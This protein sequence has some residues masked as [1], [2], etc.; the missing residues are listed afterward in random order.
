MHASVE[1]F[2]PLYIASLPTPWTHKHA[3]LYAHPVSSRNQIPRSLMTF[4]LRTQQPPPWPQLPL[5]HYRRPPVHLGS[6]APS[7]RD[8]SDATRLPQPLPRRSSTPPPRTRTTT[9]NLL[10][11]SVLSADLFSSKT[12]AT[13]PPSPRPPRGSSS[14]GRMPPGTATPHTTPR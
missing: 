9:F 3:L 12:M 11:S 6:I 10:L 14:G 4:R 7:R 5:P 8:M 2:N 1:S 13:H